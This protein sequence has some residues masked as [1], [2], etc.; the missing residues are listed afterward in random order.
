MVDFLATGG[1]GYTAFTEGTDLVYGT[2]DIDAL[3]MYMGSLPEPVDAK[4]E[5]RITRTA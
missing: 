4:A 1:D 2:V 3:V 5:A